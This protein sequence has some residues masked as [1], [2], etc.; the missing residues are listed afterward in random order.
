VNSSYNASITATNS[1][2]SYGATGLPAGLSVNTSTGVISGTP[3]ASGTFSVTLSATN[4]GGTGTKQLSLVISPVS[5]PAP[6]VTNSS[7]PSGTVN[8]AYSTTITASN[9]PTSFGASGLPAGL[10]VNTSNGVITGTP[11]ASGTFNVTLSATNATGTGTKVLSLVINPVSTGIPV[12]NN[13]SLAAGSVGNTYSVTISATNS[14]TSY[15]AT[16]LPSGLS[17]NASNG[18]ISGQPTETGSF[19]VVLRATNASGNG[20]K[21][22]TLSVT[23]PAG[24]ASVYRAPG[25]ITINGSLSESGWNVTRVASKTTIGTPNNTVRFATM[26]DNTNLYV[27]VRVLDATLNNDHANI[28]EDDA[29]EIYID[30][31]NNKLTSYDGRDNQIIKGYN[32]GS[33]F[34]KLAITGLQH[35]W[36]AVTG[37]YSIEL[38]IPWTQLG[39]A[40]TPAAGT[41]IGFDVGNND[42]DNGGT[43]D[44][45]TV[46]N[47]TI[48]N[49]ANTS[50]FGTIVL[51]NATRSGTSRM[52]T[53]GLYDPEEP[54]ADS[55]ITYWPN[56]VIDVLHISTDGSFERVEVVDL[57]GR[58][59]ISESI[60]G[61]QEVTL[62]VSHLAGG[63][64]IVKM[65]GG[66]KSHAFRII[67][68]K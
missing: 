10:N 20:T 44:A 41:K 32:D 34:T 59:H 16:G 1:P 28:W 42:D 62:D 61:K 27:G 64:H 43:R 46:W 36:V 47:G 37:G 23:E 19:S 7:L 53:D 6:V 17:V 25:A 8:S 29:V 14:P 3:T 58:Q 11:T 57:I 15:G 13:T 21:T 50:A 55:D 65:R 30:A 26:W 31:N 52:A 5:Q 18:V 40:S 35:G 45:Q 56:K 38:A 60:F 12:I 54:E 49:H 4:E 39:F 51:S 2:T 63:L 67:K 24:V 22:L 48:N 33:V 9:N 66:E 68:K